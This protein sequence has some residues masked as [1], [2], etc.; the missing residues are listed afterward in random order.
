MGTPAEAHQGPFDGVLPLQSERLTKRQ[1]DPV[2]L[3]C[4]LCLL[5]NA[6]TTSNALVNLL[7]A[8]RLGSNLVTSLFYERA[9]SNEEK[10]KDGASF[11]VAKSLNDD[12]MGPPPIMS[13][14]DPA[15]NTL[16][17]CKDMADFD[18]EIELR[19]SL[20]DQCVGSQASYKAN[21]RVATPRHS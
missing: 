10:M 6:T 4:D 11:L 18:D 3:P 5:P 17:D 14:V 12:R 21:F 8:H 13:I 19:S 7:D 16:L 1:Y 2:I 9:A 15:S 20:F